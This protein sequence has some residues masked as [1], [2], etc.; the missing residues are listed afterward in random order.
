M[1]EDLKGHNLTF[2]EIAKLVGENWQSLPPREKEAYE[3]RANSA[4]EKYHRDL[5]EYKKTPEYKKY[6]EYLQEF[7]EKQAKQNQGMLNNPTW[8]IV[9]SLIADANKRPKVEPPR[10]RHGS[11]SSSAATGVTYGSTS[12]RES[13]SSSEQNTVTEIPRSRDR[14]NSLGGMSHVSETMQPSPRSAH[15]DFN[16]QRPIRDGAHNGDGRQA[17]PSLSDIMDEGGVPKMGPFAVDSHPYTTSGFMPAN[18]RQPIPEV[19]QP[20]VSSKPA[21]ALRREE[22]S[23]NTSDSLASAT[24]SASAG[25]SATSLSKSS[26]DGVPIHALLTNQSLPQY[27]A[28]NV[29]PKSGPAASPVDHSKPTSIGSVQPTGPQGYGQFISFRGL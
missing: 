8:R 3:S 25:S 4:K 6:S 5:V 18:A 28:Q 15:F 29:S 1:R 11:T 12:M 7:K 19:P 21:P 2:T 9:R 13:R 23:T 24:S 14:G 16:N 17:L 22:S 10:I 26:G 27:P 20:L